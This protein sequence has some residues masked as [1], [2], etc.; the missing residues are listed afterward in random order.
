M[1]ILTL[2]EYMAQTEPVYMPIVKLQEDEYEVLGQY[3][4][5][6]GQQDEEERKEIKI[7]AYPQYTYLQRG[8]STQ[9]YGIKDD[10]SCNTL[11]C[12]WIN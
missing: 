1:K 8:L 9:L 3:T 11:S 5:H 10:G 12:F 7:K 2:S 6:K 4:F